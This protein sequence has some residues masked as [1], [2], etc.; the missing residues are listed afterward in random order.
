MIDINLIPVALRK[1]GKGNANSLKINIP[2]EVLFGVGAGLLFLMV[3]VHLLLGAVWLMGAGRL[4][5]YQAEWQKVLPDR[6]ILDSINKE[7]GDLKRKIK[8]ISDMTVNKS[9]PWAPK[10]NAISD[11]LPRGVWIRKMTLDKVG[12]TMEGSVVSKSEN[13]INNVGKFLAVLKQKDDFM[14]GFSSLE[15]NSIQGGKNNSIEVTDFSVMAKLI[16]TKSNEPRPK[17]DR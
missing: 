13:E 9:V 6:V 1:D 4:S 7:S 10:F 17:Q 11:S 12:L 5:H 8:M 16:E 14:K 2:K 15:V 3:M